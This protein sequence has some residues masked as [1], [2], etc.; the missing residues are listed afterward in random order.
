MVTE[1][2]P[3]ASGDVFL[4]YN[5]LESLDPARLANATS[6][7]AQGN[8]LKAVPLLP[9]LVRIDVAHNKIAEF[10]AGKWPGLQTLNVSYNALSTFPNLDAPELEVRLVPLA[11]EPLA[12]PEGNRLQIFFGQIL[13]NFATNFLIVSTK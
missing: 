8:Y 5:R 13:R 12:P 1:P 9:K 3:V 7:D 2:R 11:L 4:G 6:L 10:P